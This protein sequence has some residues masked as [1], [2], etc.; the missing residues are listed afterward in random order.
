MWTRDAVPCWRCKRDGPS[1][2]VDVV[3]ACQCTCKLEVELKNAGRISIVL[4]SILTTT[5]VHMA[6]LPMFQNHAVL[7]KKPVSRQR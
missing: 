5:L 6:R 4:A 2:V 3:C 1:R 7:E